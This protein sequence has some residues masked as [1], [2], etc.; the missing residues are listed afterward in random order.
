MY[1]VKKVC[2]ASLHNVYPC[3]SNIILFSGN[4][5]EVFFNVNTEGKRPPVSLPRGT[6]D[7]IEELGTPFEQ[8][9]VNNGFYVALDTNY[10]R[11]FVLFGRGLQLVYGDR[12]GD[13]ITEATTYNMEE[14]AMVYPPQIPRDSRHREYVA[15]LKDNPH[16]CW[17]PW[18]R[19]GVYHWGMWMERGHPE[20]GCVITRDTNTIPAH[21]TPVLLTLFRALGNLT[22]AQRLLFGAVDA[23]CRSDYEAVIKNCP[24][25]KKKIWVTDSDIECFALRAC[26]INVFTEPHYDGGD[27][28]NGWASMAPFGEFKDGDFCITELQ[29]RFVYKPG[30]ISFLKARR[31]EHF[32]LGWKGHRF[33]LVATTHESL[34][35][36]LDV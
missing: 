20:K 21:V 2:P 25:E 14:Y 34:R 6:L 22:R 33:C 13:H 15:W 4:I 31:F 8:V 3:F 30:D 26:L 19:M 5:I 24:M 35:N 17:P 18:A 7:D 1:L 12:I 16:L 27:W 36:S 28:E 9:K 29:R 32:T 11:I 10:R 23:A